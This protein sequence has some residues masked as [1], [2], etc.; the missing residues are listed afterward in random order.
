MVA[1]SSSSSEDDISLSVDHE[2]ALT[3]T[4]NAASSSVVLQC[5]GGVS[6]QRNQFTHKYKIG[7]TCAPLF[8][9]YGLENNQP[10]PPS[11][12]LPLLVFREP[13]VTVAPRGSQV[14]ICSS[15]L[16]IYSCFCYPCMYPACNSG[17]KW[18]SRKSK[19]KM[20]PPEASSKE[21]N[22]T[23]SMFPL[24]YLPLFPAPA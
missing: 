18:V 8:W 11:L 3:P 16:A 10:P 4:R 12:A 20:S 15:L 22:Q 2:E 9:P 21:P 17:N 19:G 23:Q 1:V 7:D 24:L 13:N 5:K 14:T 6:L